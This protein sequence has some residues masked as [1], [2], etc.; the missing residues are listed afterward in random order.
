MIRTHVQ[1]IWRGSSSSCM[2]GFKNIHFIPRTTECVREAYRTTS[3]QVSPDSYIQLRLCFGLGE[4]RFSL[5]RCCLK[6]RKIKDFSSSVTSSTRS[7][8]SLKSS[9]GRFAGHVTS[10]SGG[11]EGLTSNTRGSGSSK[12][13]WEIAGGLNSYACLLI[14]CFATVGF[15]QA[16]HL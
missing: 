9:S 13:T 15:K 8:E 16:I 11:T 2:Y 4:F 7:S 6:L 14:L 5:D 1:I 3:D 12:S 10:G